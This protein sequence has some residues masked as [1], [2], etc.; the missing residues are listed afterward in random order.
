VPES[1]VR[2][3]HA[4]SS[5][6]GSA[7]K[8]YFDERNHLVVLARHAAATNAAR[9]AARSLLVTGSYARRDVLAPALS[10]RPLHTEVV[11]QRLRSFGGFLRMLPRALSARRA[12]R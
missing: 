7:F 12:S 5:V 3:L 6:D 2:H 10:S 11:G 8:R 1:V 4:S 9:A